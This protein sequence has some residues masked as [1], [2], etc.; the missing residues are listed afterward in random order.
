M[1]DMAE[2]L[3]LGSSTLFEAGPGVEV[4][5][6]ALRPMW[7]GARV[8][9]PAY[10]VR[11][12]PGDNLAIH[13]A[14]ARLPSGSVLVVECSGEVRG[15]WGEVLTVA[16][17]ARGV[18]GLVING[19]VRDIDAMAHLRFPVFARARCVRGTVKQHAPSVGS[20]LV[21]AGAKIAPQDIIVGDADGVIAIPQAR[22][23]DI[24]AAAR[25]RSQAEQ[26]FMEKLRAGSTTLELLGLTHLHQQN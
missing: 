19:G 13:V 5:D 4:L 8:A 18:L 15:Y 16:A 9:G 2:L 14:L 12:A 21:V 17:Q 22:M 3:A 23:G 10:T 25:K 20:P 7:A 24:V 11:C 6:P 26:A 1:P